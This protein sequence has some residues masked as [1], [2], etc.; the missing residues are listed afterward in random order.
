M[1]GSKQQST[2]KHV[3]YTATTLHSLAYLKHQQHKHNQSCEASG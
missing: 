1:H 3:T 2:V